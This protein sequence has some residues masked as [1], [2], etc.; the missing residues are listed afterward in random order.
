MGLLICLIFSARAW[1]AG[2]I[3]YDTTPRAYIFKG[4][5]CTIAAAQGD[6]LGGRVQS[7]AFLAYRQ[8][9][10]VNIVFCLDPAAVVTLKVM[11]AEA[12]YG[13]PK[14]HR[15]TAARGVG[16]DARFTYRL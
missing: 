14:W 15:R 3:K 2:K 5:L 12:A 8:A 6:G 10:Y 4:A 7:D 16:I 13:R 9:A 11:T 1:R